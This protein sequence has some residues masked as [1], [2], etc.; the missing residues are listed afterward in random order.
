[1]NGTNRRSRQREKTQAQTER[2]TDLTAHKI[3]AVGLIVKVYVG[4]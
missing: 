1:M 4:G 3:Q 2:K